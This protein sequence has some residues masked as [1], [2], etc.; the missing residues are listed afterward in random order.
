M[1]RRRRILLLALL[2]LQGCIVVPPQ[3][4]T[5]WRWSRP[6]TSYDEFLKARY[7]CLGGSSYYSGYARADIF[8]NC[9]SLRA[10]RIDPFG[11]FVAPPGEPL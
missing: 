3:A 9:M 10:Y 4:Y 11:P 8:Y 6:A 2:L 7:Y 5:P 1:A